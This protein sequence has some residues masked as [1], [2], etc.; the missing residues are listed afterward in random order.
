MED[1]HEKSHGI[2][3]IF[4]PELIQYHKASKPENGREMGASEYDK[5][6][7]THNMSE[8]ICCAADV[9]VDARETFFLSKN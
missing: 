9:A 7:C 6:E 8:A 3:K 1:E 5:Q 4:S 2:I